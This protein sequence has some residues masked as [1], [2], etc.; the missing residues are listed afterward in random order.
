MFLIKDVFEE[1]QLKGLG[2]LQRIEERS[3]WSENS[4]GFCT[5]QQ[6]KKQAIGSLMSSVQSVI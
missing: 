5:E 3:I 2:I 6:W 1:K 4:L